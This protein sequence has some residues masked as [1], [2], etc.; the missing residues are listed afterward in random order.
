[1][2]DNNVIEFDMLMSALHETIQF[3][4]PKQLCKAEI[5]V[6]T[7]F[8]TDCYRITRLVYVLASIAKA[9]KLIFRKNR[10]LRQEKWSVST[11]LCKKEIRHIVHVRAVRGRLNHDF[12]DKTID[13]EKMLSSLGSR[14]TKIGFRTKIFFPARDLVEFDSRTEVQRLK[15]SQL[16]GVRGRLN[17]DSIRTRFEQCYR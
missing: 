16:G 12:A 8:R 13:V 7:L 15:W 10:E 1:M 11:S 9:P 4:W 6:L 2:K 5:S 17:H 3:W 14:K